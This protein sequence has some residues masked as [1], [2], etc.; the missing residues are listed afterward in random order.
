[1]E[2]VIDKDKV[3]KK[4]YNFFKIEIENNEIIEF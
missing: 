3:T 4:I 2:L 1:M